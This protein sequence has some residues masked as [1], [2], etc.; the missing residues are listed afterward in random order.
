M[1]M[2]LISF[3]ENIVQILFYIIQDFDFISKTQTDTCGINWMRNI[4]SVECEQ[5]NTHTNKTVP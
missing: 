3:V 4:F 2:V 5:Q 1:F